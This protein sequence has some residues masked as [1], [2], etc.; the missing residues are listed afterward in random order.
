[1]DAHTGDPGGTDR[2]GAISKKT[3]RDHPSARVVH[4]LYPIPL[5]LP[6]IPN[7]IRPNGSVPHQNGITDD[8]PHLPKAVLTLPD[9]RY[10][11]FSFHTK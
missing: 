10:G 6:T 1:M 9:V 5:V 8:I 11:M 4:P 2:V 3:V 7:S